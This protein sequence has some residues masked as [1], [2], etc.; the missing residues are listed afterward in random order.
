ML[1]SALIDW[2]R[3]ALWVLA[4]SNLQEI[5][6]CSQGNTFARV[7]FI[8]KEALAQVFPFPVDFANFLKTPLLTEHLLRLLLAFQSE[9]TKIVNFDIIYRQCHGEELPKHLLKQYQTVDDKSA[10]EYSTSNQDQIL[11]SAFCTDR[12][13]IFG[14]KKP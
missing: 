11:S 8:K 12:K 5:S 4:M 1:Y 6:Q 13:D 7:S 14:G 10:L 3:F 2:L 9:S